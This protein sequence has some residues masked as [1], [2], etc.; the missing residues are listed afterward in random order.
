MVLHRIIV[1]V[2]L[3]KKIFR[4]SSVG[5]TLTDAILSLENNDCKIRSNYFSKVTSSNNFADLH[6]SFLNS[7]E[8]NKLSFQSDQVVLRVSST[9]G[10]SPVSVDKVVQ[11]FEAF[12]KQA[13][14]VVNFPEIRRVGIVAEY[15]IDPKNDHC[16]ANQLIE[17]LLTVPP[18]KHSGRFHLTYEDRE[19]NPDGTVPDKA[20]GDFWS[21]IYTYYLSEID[22]TPAEGKIVASMDTQKYYNP[23]K[24]NI[25]AE[26][27]SVKKVFIKNKS[28]F[29][30]LL[31][32][33]GL[34]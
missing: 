34:E 20:S 19:L 18:A 23:A 16:A 31:Q 13:D 8:T 21:T 1:G 9:E 2:L 14:K 22:E 5:G 27:K 25:L 30:A 32:E 4:L 7:E 15:R 28:K 11:Q 6:V 24:S 29:K 10:N 17:T 12:W 26:L 33:M 3:N